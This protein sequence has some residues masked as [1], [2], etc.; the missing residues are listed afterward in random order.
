AGYKGFYY[1]FIDKK[2]GFRAWNCELSTIDSGLLI[3]GAIFCQ[4]YFDGT[5]SAEIEIRNLAD[6][7]YYRIDWQ[8]AMAS[9]EGIAMGWKPEEGFHDWIWHGYNEAMILYILALGSPT[10][11]VPASAWETWTSTYKWG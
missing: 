6:S 8:W 3:A 5:T 1:H 7:L 4:S 11:P 2:T 9:R 10:H